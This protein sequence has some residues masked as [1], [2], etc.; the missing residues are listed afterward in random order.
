MPVY[1]ASD[2]RTY[3]ISIVKNLEREIL[4]VELKYN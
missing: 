3:E 1:K 4:W 2:R